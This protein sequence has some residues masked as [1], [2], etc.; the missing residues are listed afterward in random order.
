MEDN[1]FAIVKYNKPGF[2]SENIIV[3]NCD[4]SSVALIIAR[5]QETSQ[6]EFLQDSPDSTVEVEIVQYND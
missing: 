1:K 6:H 5:Q 3:P 2:K 4:N